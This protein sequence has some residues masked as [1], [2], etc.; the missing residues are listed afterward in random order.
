MSSE[1]RS[2]VW[3]FSAVG[4]DRPGIVAALSKIFF[5]QACNL[6]DSSMTILGGQ[7]AVVMLLETGAETDEAQLQ[8]ELV[9]LGQEWKLKVAAGPVDQA[10][11]VVPDAS[12]ETPH[13]VSV[14]G[15][16]QAGIT[17]K[18]TDL[19]ACHH[20]NVTDLSTRRIEGSTPVYILLIEVLP[21]SDQADLTTLKTALASLGKDLGCSVSVK[22][23]ESA[24]L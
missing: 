1:N 19:I 12:T 7:F 15:A 6:L 24:S 9:R 22:E 8:E 23:V 13:L 16:D 18:V 21:A 11:E 14:Y 4:R 17:W 20:F 3:S 2:N 5:D 10:G